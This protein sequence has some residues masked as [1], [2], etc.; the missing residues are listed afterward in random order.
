[1]ILWSD[2]PANFVIKALQ[3]AEVSG[4]VVD[5]ETHSMD[6]VVQEDQLAQAIGRG[7]QN[8]RL[9]S[10]LT[11]WQLNIVTVEEAAQKS[12]EESES[13]RSL[14]MSK[15]DL[16]EDVAD[17][18]IAE[19]F[20]TLEEIAYVPIAEMLE[21]DGFDEDI[22]NELRE[23]ARNVLLTEAI[24][25]EERVE[26]AADIA[27]LEGIDAAT[28]ATLAAAG[29]HTQQ[30]LADLATDELVEITGMGEEHA[31]ALIM[32]ARAPWFAEG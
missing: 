17:V 26:E 3:P 2:E 22:V 32:K 28:V 15:L 31:N 8:V 6:V 24:S 1:I 11:G 16:D 7:G 14:F 21:I 20:S 18:L 10:E 13:I 29:I 5:E 23:R 12:A 27:T 9:A 4:I 19:G 25:T 30:A